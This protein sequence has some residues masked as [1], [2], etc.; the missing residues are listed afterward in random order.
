MSAFL[1]R[2]AKRGVA[3]ATQSQALNALVFLY[4]KVL[5]L[6]LNGVDALRV[7]RPAAVRTALSLEETRALLGA[8]AA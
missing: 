1:T 8:M 6:P 2:E 7:R 3:A 5:N 4:G